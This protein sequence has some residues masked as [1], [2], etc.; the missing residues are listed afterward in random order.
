MSKKANPTFVG[1]FIVLGLALGIVGLIVFSSG[2]LFS[3]QHRFILY[4][5][6]SLKGLNPGAPVKLR[7]VT[8]GSV[9]E[10]LIAHNQKTNDFAMPVI[11]E[12]SQNLLQAK[13]DRHLR[14]TSEALL[15]E[16]LDAWFAG[17]P[18]AAS[19]DVANVR[20]VDGIA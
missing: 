17:E 8:I 19:D 10:V 4:F 5:N 18:S 9:V 11:I 3:K 12:I 2:K 14:T 16:I 13:S 6:A 20:H 7:G 15:E 1:I